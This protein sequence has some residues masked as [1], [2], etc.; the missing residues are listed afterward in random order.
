MT[1]IF[2]KGKH[3]SI[4]TNKQT[5]YSVNEGNKVIRTRER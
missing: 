4:K 1:F 5:I 3:N 2:L